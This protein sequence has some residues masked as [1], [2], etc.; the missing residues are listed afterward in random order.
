MAILAVKFF[1]NKVPFACLTLHIFKHQSLLIKK[2]LEAHN[3]YTHIAIQ[4][5]VK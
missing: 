1:F 5:Q 2:E 3:G 4:H